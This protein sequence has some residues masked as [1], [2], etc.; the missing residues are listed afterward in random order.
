VAREKTRALLHL[1]LLVLIG[2]DALTHVP[3]QNPT[4]ERAVFEPHLKVLQELR[5]LPEHG[6]SR[7]M[8]TPDADM[9]L[10]YTFTSVPRNDYIVN[11]AGLFSNCN[12]LE[13]IPKLNGFYSLYLRDADDVRNLIYAGTNGPL[14]ALYDF[15]GVSQITRPGEYFEWTNRTTFMPLVSAGQ[16]PVFT[17]ESAVLR[18]LSSTNFHPREEV[19][20]PIEART[21][22]QISDPTEAKIIST[23]FSS[24]RGEIRLQAAKPTFVVLAQAFYD[25]WQPYVDG[26]RTKLWRANYAFQALEV[27]EG[28][29]NVTLVYEDR[30][31]WLGA[32]TSGLTLI[33]CCLGLFMSPA[34]SRQGH[35]AAGGIGAE[36]D[37]SRGGRGRPDGVDVV[38]LPNH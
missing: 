25:P 20:L 35:V 8:V 12:L 24:Q 4:V 38:S 17:N 23:R 34:R 28:V 6:E 2:L 16:K 26:R 21:Q 5:P 37:R 18:T 3:R 36:F 22:T 33:G 14:P 9:K 19:Y 29:H 15:L 31:F 30:K 27:P 1:V 11:R 13:D 32:A 7:A 10:R